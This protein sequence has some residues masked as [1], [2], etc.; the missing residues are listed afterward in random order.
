M[1]WPI[2]SQLT[3]LNHRIINYWLLAVVE[4][5]VVAAVVVA[6]QGVIIER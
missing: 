6:V 1:L 5:A 4:I 3:S 2:D